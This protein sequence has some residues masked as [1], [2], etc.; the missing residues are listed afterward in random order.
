M[1]IRDRN[2][3]Y[4]TDDFEFGQ[5]KGRCFTSYDKNTILELWEH[6]WSLISSKRQEVMYNCLLMQPGLF[7]KIHG[8]D[9]PEYGLDC[10]RCV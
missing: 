8:K 9:K 10:S 5:D 4:H 7:Y 6:D 3:I 1:C 2:A